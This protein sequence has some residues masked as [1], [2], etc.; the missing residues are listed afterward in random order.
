M[1]RL[2]FK[3]FLLTVLVL[4]FSKWAFEQLLASRVYADRQRVVTGVHL[5]GMRLVAR[6]LL[7]GPEDRR[8]NILSKI[9]LQFRAPLELRPLSELEPKER[10]RL[11]EPYGYSYRLADNYSE[12]LSVHFD[13]EQ[14][15]R[16]GPFNDYSTIAFEDALWGWL[17]LLT[18]RYENSDKTPPELDQLSKDFGLPIKLLESQDLPASGSNRFASGRDV[19]FYE[20]QGGYYAATKLQSSDS[21]MRIGPLPEFKDVTTPTAQTTLGLAFLGSAILIGLLVNSIARKFNKLA[22]V[23]RA[24][25]QGNLGARVQE[26]NAGEARELAT[27]LNLMASKTETLIQSKRELLQM[28]SHELRTPLARLRFAVDLI[29]A[30]SDDPKRTRRMEIINQSINDLEMLVNEILEYIRNREELPSRSQEWIDVRKAIEPISKALAEET[31]QLSIEFESNLPG[32]QTP[33]IY[34]DRIAFLRVAKNLLGNAQRYAKSRLV[35]RVY[36]V[37]SE[38]TNNYQADPSR[39]KPQT[40]VEFEDD[41]PGIPEDKWTEVIEPF[42]RISDPSS[43]IPS[44]TKEAPWTNL[45]HRSHAGIGLGL[46][47]VSR[48][49]NQHGGSIQIGRGKLGGCVVRTYWPNLASQPPMV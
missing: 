25:A 49:L 36:Q 18:Y 41:G 1:I 43:W 15:L 9:Q 47:I 4:L 7:S 12:H 29:E 17:Q 46:A 33:L 31:P 38:T 34:A 45:S 26:G 13:S 21:Y 48:I 44:N 2:F 24:I 39:S 32:Q 19:A 10:S 30:K 37:K 27:A 42:V 5:G 6:Q 11:S 14:Y 23:A 8:E 35:V 20:D 22:R 16:L 40:C 28:V 3:F